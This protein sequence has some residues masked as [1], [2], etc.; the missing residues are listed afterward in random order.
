MS[1]SE[2]QARKQRP[3]PHFPANAGIQIILNRLDSGS[4]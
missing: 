4:S 3:N 1:T 2:I